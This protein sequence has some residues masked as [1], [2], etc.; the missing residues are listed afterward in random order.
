MGQRDRTSKPVDSANNT[1]AYLMIGCVLFF[2]ISVIAHKYTVV[3][4]Q[5]WKIIFLP[6][7]SAI[8]VVANS[9]I[10]DWVNPLIGTT[11]I[12]AHTLTQFISGTSVQHWRGPGFIAMNHFIGQYLLLIFFPIGVYGTVFIFKKTQRMGNAFQRFKNSRLLAAY[13]MSPEM[14]RTVALSSK[15]EGCKK[16]TVGALSGAQ[17]CE[18][19]GLITTDKTKASV[20]DMDVEA[21]FQ[22]F[23][24]QLGPRLTSKADFFAAEYGWVAYR[25]VQY[26]PLAH[27]AGVQPIHDVRMML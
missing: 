20:S 26:I 9:F 14:K 1:T 24:H 23:R 7:A 15:S 5:G 22:V 12:Q 3:F 17:F 21:A 18:Q 27:R 19:H 16:D 25:I 8:D 13:T 4:Y 6:L 2:V 11:K 10:G